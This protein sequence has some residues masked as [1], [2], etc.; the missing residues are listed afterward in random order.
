[1]VEFTPRVRTFIQLLNREDVPDIFLHY[2]E[3]LHQLLEN[4]SA[5]IS[6]QYEHSLGEVKEQQELFAKLLSNGQTLLITVSAI[7]IIFIIG[8]IIRASKHITVPLMQLKEQSIAAA[9]GRYDTEINFKSKDELGQLAQEFN[10]MIRAISKEI[11]D[12]KV[13]EESLAGFKSTLDN[14]LDCVFMF[15]PETLRFI[16]VNNGATEQVGYDSTALL[17]MTPLDIKPE[18]D[19]PRFRAM[20][21]PLLS[22]EKLS[23]TFET[24]HRHR[25][26]HLIPVEIFLQYVHPKP[27]KSRFVAIVRDVSERKHNE[28]SIA[29][30][31]RQNELILNAA[32]EGIYGIDLQG[33]VTFINPAAT[34]MIGWEKS[35]LIAQ[36]SHEIFHHSY[37]DGTPYPSNECPIYASF[38]SGKMHF[39]NDEIFWRKDGTS[40]SVEYVS[41]PILEND[42][43]MGSVVIFRDI[44]ERKQMEGALHQAKENAESANRAKSAFLATMSHEIRTPMN[45]ILGMTELLRDSELTKTQNLYVKTLHHS[46]ESLLALINDILD[47]SKI[48]ADQMILER[49]V[50]DLKLSIDNTL[51]L[52]K[53]TA[54]DKGIELKH[55]VNSSVTQWVQGDPTRLH[56]VLLNLVGNAIKFTQDLGF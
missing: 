31:S 2:Q 23:L 21:T 38:V 37:A 20:I 29:I 34:K 1:L 41:T 15:D 40:F 39:A 4:N 17:Q 6:S 14:T 48:E 42:Q 9:Q 26:G 22:G 8:V 7:I 30:L 47:L 3:N 55:Q 33:R 24:V 5:L 18:I 16:Y 56:Q 13:I 54:L 12:R 19:E 27:G 10:H 51:E 32:G 49:A 50:F 53:L 46:S 28:E 43:I 45:S 36:P 52:F 25:D 44:T 11:T 35:Y